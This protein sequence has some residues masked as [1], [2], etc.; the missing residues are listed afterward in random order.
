LDDLK[1]YAEELGITERLDFLGSVPQKRIMELIEASDVFVLPSVPVSDGDIDGIP[2]SLMEAMAMGCPV[3]STYVS[4][5]PELITDEKS[6]LLVQP[7]DPKALA[8]AIERLAKDQELYTLVADG[9]RREVEDNFNLALVGEQLTGFFTK[10]GENY[11][12]NN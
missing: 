5:I 12:R 7:N 2:V 8:M 9:G 11:Y 3:V 4:G 10:I 6:G 1:G